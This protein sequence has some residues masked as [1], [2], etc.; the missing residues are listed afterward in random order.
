MSKRRV[1]SSRSTAIHE[2]GHAVACYRFWPTRYVGDLTIVEDRENNA[3]GSHETLEALEFPWSDDSE[4]QARQDAEF[5][6]G[7]IY[8]CAGYAA[9]IVAG[10]PEADAARGAWSD[11]ER[12]EHCTRVPLATSKQRAVELMTRPENVAAVTRLADELIA[13]GTI[14]SEEIDF[15]IDIADGNATE[16]DYKRFVLLRNRAPS[17][18]PVEDDPVE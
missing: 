11:F 6:K 8:Y 12:A 7:A 15:L 3:A 1:L 4:E 9:T 14:P 16:E 13:R 5:E 18:D 17:P 10:I 2:A